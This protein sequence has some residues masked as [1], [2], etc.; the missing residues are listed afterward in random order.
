MSLPGREPDP[1]VG[2]TGAVRIDISAVEKDIVTGRRGAW[3]AW[4]ERIFCVKH[5][6][7]DLIGAAVVPVRDREWSEI[8]IVVQR[9]WAV[10]LDRAGNAVGILRGHVGMIPVLVRPSFVD[11]GVTLLTMRSRTGWH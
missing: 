10:D 4:N 6:L 2:T 7:E 11:D 8:N 1:G 5:T 9:C 3:K